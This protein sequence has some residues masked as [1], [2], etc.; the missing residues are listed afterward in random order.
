MVAYAF[1]PST[2]EAEAGGFLSSRP[3]WSTKW[4]PGQPGLNRETLSRKKKIAG[5]TGGYN[6]TQLPDANNRA[7]ITSADSQELGSILRKLYMVVVGG[8][9]SSQVSLLLMRTK[10]EKSLLNPVLQWQAAPAHMTVL[11]TSP[12][13]GTSPL[14]EAEFDDAMPLSQN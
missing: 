3:A 14:E 5:F 9:Q 4:V 7:C 13:Q 6:H 11:L 10:V 1:S 12:G 8:K 2:R